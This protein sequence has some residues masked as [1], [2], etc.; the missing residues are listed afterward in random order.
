[1]VEANNSLSNIEKSKSDSQTA[2]FKGVNFTYNPQIFGEVKS[3]E[4]AELP[5]C[6]NCKPDSVAPEHLLFTLEDSS[7]NRKTKIYIFPIEDYRRMYAVS[8]EVT[9]AFDE[10]LKGLKKTIKDKNFRIK[11]QIPFIPFWDGSQTFLSKVKNFSF[12][13]G[14]GIF[15]L[16]QF[17]IEVSLINNG[18]LI[19]CFEGITSDE[20]YYI[21]AVFP[22]KVPFLPGKY[23]EE[24]EGYKVPEKGFIETDAELKLYKKYV[25]RIAKRLE[26]LPPEK[27]EPNLNYFEE[28]ISSL[29][30]EK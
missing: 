18:S 14:K 3:E 10:E 8:N 7:S 30:I 25:A 12:Q 6:E 21:L 17:D 22:V 4:V 24:S 15:F 27:Y 19:Y 23:T 20:K 28:V 1:M 2:N 29:K 5:L 13:N 11:N 26:N 9:K 16:T